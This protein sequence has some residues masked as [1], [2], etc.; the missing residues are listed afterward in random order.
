[1]CRRETQG[2]PTSC[3]VNVRL[4]FPSAS[5][6]D[7]ATTLHS[8]ARASRT[9]PRGPHGLQTDRPP[10]RASEPAPG[11]AGEPLPSLPLCVSVSTCERVH[12]CVKKCVHQ[13]AHHC[14]W[15]A[16]ASRKTDKSYA[17]I[18]PRSHSVLGVPAVLPSQVRPIAPASPPVAAVL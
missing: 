5:S 13:I 15:A 3:R 2:V 17:K 4:S 10:P 7:S 8:A 11:D 12:A 14:G 6:R 16:P 1:M 18:P 9:Q